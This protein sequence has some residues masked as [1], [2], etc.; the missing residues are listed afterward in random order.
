MYSEKFFEQSVAVLRIVL[1]IVFFW[2]GALKVI[3]LSPAGPLV[4]SLFDK[5]LAGFVPFDAFYVGFAWFEV[6]LGILFLVPQATRLV[7][8]LLAAHLVTTAGPLVLLPNEVWTAPFV[9][10]LEG[11]YI[12]KNL[13]IIA[14]AITIAA[15][16]RPLA[17]GR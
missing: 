13:F 10:T 3:G 11:Q 4:R 7:L 9:P 8:V 14:A 5:T 12:I 2:F 15:R 17:E 16:L 6:A 1:G